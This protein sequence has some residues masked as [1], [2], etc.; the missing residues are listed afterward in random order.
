MK[1]IRCLILGILLMCAPALYSAGFST[2]SAVSNEAYNAT[3]WNGVGYMAPSKNAVRDK[4]ESGLIGK[5]TITQPANG[6]TLTIADG[7]TLTATGDAQVGQGVTAWTP[8][9]TPQGGSFT[10]VG[11]VSGAYLTIGKIVIAQYS[12]RITDKGT[13][14]GSLV[15][16]GLPFT[17]IN[18]VFMGSGWDGSTGIMHSVNLAAGGTSLIVSKYDGT[19]PYVN[20]NANIGTIVFVSE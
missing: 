18:Y 5:V 10:T 13:G 3:T 9:P 6:S 14:T 1:K 12:V 7:K 2:G 16:A 11:A 4:I 8:V 15:I 20:T 19:A 17:N